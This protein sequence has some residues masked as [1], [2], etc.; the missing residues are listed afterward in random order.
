MLNN[1]PRTVPAR[2][3]T[4]QAMVDWSYGL[5]DPS[6]QTIFCRFSGFAASFSREAAIAVAGTDGASPWHV[7]EALQRM[8]DCSL[9]QFDDG[10]RPRYRFLETLRVYGAKKLEEHGEA[11]TIAER[12][13][14]Y[15]QALFDP[16]D[17]SWETMPDAEWLRK[18]EL[19]IDNIRV[20]L[21]RALEKPERTLKGI[22]LCG[23]TGRL[24]YMLSLVPEGRLYCDKFVEL[25]DENTPAVHAARLLKRAAILWRFADRLRA[26]ALLERSAALYRQIEDRPNLGSVLG[27]VAG[28]YFHLGRHAEAGVAFKEARESL[29]GSNR[30]KSQIN[31]MT[32]LGSFALVMN[33]PDEAC[34]HYLV[35]RDLARQAKDITRENNALIN[36]GEAECAVGAI[37]QAIE[38]AREAISGLRAADQS[39]R[40][41]P[42]LT[43]LASYLIFH[44]DYG[45]ARLHATEALSLLIEEGG[46]FL[47]HCLQVWALIAAIEG[48]YP[49]AAQ[50]NGFVDIRYR[51]S[52]EIRERTEQ[53]IYD[54]L[55]EILAANLTTDNVS[56]FAT[57]GSS[58]SEDH[59]VDFVFRRIISP[60]NLMP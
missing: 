49:E 54:R 3:Q 43:N 5:L 44:R 7:A 14:G 4:L 8:V 29:S 41:G 18:Y 19:E 6:D 59:A 16:A 56:A 45:E 30:I 11:E 40:C 60:Q 13:I 36:L 42:P 25:I 48:R 50:L 33:E 2:H 53:Q 57:E 47:K 39:S 37:D 55:L 12:Q 46:Y 24:W 28:D 35:A 27:L 32:D 26:V 31:V 1:G 21:D 23:A 9:L 51:R 34:R 17:E 15:L 10:E 52:G 20:A 58:W 22:A 38:C